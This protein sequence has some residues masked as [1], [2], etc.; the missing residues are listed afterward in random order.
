MRRSR[1]KS[2]KNFKIFIR[3]K[4]HNMFLQEKGKKMDVTVH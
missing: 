1:M 3:D 4:Y 2:Y